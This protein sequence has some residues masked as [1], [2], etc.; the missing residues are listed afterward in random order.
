MKIGKYY[1]VDAG[2]AN[3]TEFLAP[4]Q[5]VRY[6]LSEHKGR[7]PSNERELFI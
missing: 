2:Y 1:L 3:T 6:H 5:G 7:N 4:F